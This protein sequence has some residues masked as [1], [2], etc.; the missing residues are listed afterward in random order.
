MPDILGQINKQ[1]ISKTVKRAALAGLLAVL[2]VVE[3]DLPAIVEAS[4]PAGVVLAIV[5]SQA[6]TYLKSGKEI[7][8]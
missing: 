5:I 1:Q 2:I 6:I 4:T 3:A 8:G 7:K